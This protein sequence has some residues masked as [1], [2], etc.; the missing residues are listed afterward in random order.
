[1]KGNTVSI[2]GNITR[3]AEFAATQSGT[4]VA[5]FGICWN[6]SRK[7]AQGGYDDVPNFFDVVIFL[8]DRQLG[9]IKSQLVKGASCAIIDGHLSYSSWE[10]D[11]QKRSKVD[12][13]VDDP[14]QGLL[15][16]PPRSQ[17]Q[18][19][20]YQQPT[21]GA[22]PQYHPVYQPQQHVQQYQQPQQAYAP[23]MAPQP[24][25]VQPSSIY[26]EDIPF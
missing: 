5:S 21:Y 6:R 22:Q 11:G 20:Q 25:Y 18:A 12:I 10:K 19:P 16:A 26:D 7:N 4:N 8:T 14:V 1:M 23:Q 15:V 13:I 2:K 3:D 9:Y 24:S 17:Q